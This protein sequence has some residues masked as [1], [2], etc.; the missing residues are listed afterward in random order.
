MPLIPEQ[1]IYLLG[2]QHLVSLSDG[3][4][5]YSFPLY[6]TIVVQKLPAG[7]TELCVQGP[8]DPMT[9]LETKPARTGLKTV[10]A[11]LNAGWPAHLVTL[12]FHF[13][14]V[15]DPLSDVLGALQTLARSTG[16]LA[17]HVTR[18][19]LPPP[20]PLIRASTYKRLA[21]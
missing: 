6:N 8:L 17:A 11:M 14:T 18:S 9:L 16:C 21:L 5:G 10:R 19:L 15:S 1:Y 20:R 2:V 3:L 12:S 13:S 4:T 7:S